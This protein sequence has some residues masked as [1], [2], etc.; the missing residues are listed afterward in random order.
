MNNNDL[1]QTLE[2]IKNA[3]RIYRDKAANFV[4]D[5][6]ATQVFAM[7]TLYLWGDK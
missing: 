4:L 5:Q 7:D 2:G 3:K 1:T 6:V